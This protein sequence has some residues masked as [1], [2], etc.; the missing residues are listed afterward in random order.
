MADAVGL[1]GRLGF[2]GEIPYVPDVVS[3]PVARVRCAMGCGTL[4]RVSNTI[5]V[6][7]ACDAKRPATLRGTKP[8]VGTRRVSQEPCPHGCGRGRHQG[9]CAGWQRREKV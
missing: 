6:C 3:Y 2:I 5:G 1:V 9:R 4:L 8:K 7:A